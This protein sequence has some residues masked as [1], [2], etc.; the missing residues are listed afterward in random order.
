MDTGAHLG[1]LGV[2][3]RGTID[4]AKRIGLRAEA[5]A[6]S[7]AWD[8]LL[9]ATVQA[10]STGDPAEALVNATPYLQ[11]FG[12][13]VAA[14]IHLDLAV[15]ATHSDH[16]EAPGRIAAMKYFFAYELPRI[17]AWLGVVARR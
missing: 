6:L 10:W 11:G 8:E 1:A 13:V 5:D 14:W 9:V 12:H 17:G 7:G 16:S 2:E 3:V 4:A 15:A